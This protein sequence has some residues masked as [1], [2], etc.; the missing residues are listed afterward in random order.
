[1]ERAA[2]VVE[3]AAP[4]RSYS[5]SVGQSSGGSS[6]E[7]ADDAGEHSQRSRDRIRAFVGLTLGVTLLILTLFLDPGIRSSWSNVAVALTACIA[8]A[9]SGRYPVAGAVVEAI[10]LMLVWVTADKTISLSS[11]SVFLVTSM[12]IWSGHRVVIFLVTPWYLAAI[13]LVDST[14][15]SDQ[16]ELVRGTLVWFTFEMVFVLLGE[17]L[18]RQRLANINLEKQRRAELAAQRRAIARELHDTAVYSATMVVMRA[19]AARLRGDIDSRLAEDLEFIART[20]RAATADLR[21]MLEL[22]RASDSLESTP[23]FDPAVRFTIMDKPPLE[24]IEEQVAKVRAAGFKVQVAI[25][26]D[27]SILPEVVAAT[28]SRVATEACSNIVKHADRSGPVSI[29]VDANPDAVDAIFINTVPLPGDGLGALGGFPSDRPAEMQANHF[30][31]TGQQERVE[32]LGGN[33]EVLQISNRWIVRVSI[34]LH[35]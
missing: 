22:L 30:G 24:A 10:A 16:G 34:P 21:H 15:A 32:A 28:F 31:L 18:L 9:I 26:G 4:K 27:V 14:S 12:V 25:D 7:A 29:M 8:L 17:L 11:I 2:E 19:E 13:V 20:G 23:E 5:G 1:M 33:I 6:A 3:R 35:G